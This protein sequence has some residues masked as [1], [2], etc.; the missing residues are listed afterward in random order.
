MTLKGWRVVKPQHNQSIITSFYHRPCRAK[1][2]LVYITSKDPYEAVHPCSRARALDTHLRVSRRYCTNYSRK[3]KTLIR[4][5]RHAGSPKFR[6][7]LRLFFPWCGLFT[8]Y[9]N[10]AVAQEKVSLGA[11]AN[12]GYQDCQEATI[13]LRPLTCICT[14]YNIQ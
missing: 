3:V 10:C 4:M 6:I 11:N 12:S 5:H 13:W 2:G 14:F 7:S 1:I 9:Y 8:P